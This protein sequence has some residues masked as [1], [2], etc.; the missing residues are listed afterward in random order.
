MNFMKNLAVL[1]LLL[2]ALAFVAKPDDAFA[3][4]V[5]VQT[6]LASN[7]AVGASRFTVTSATGFVAS[8][9]LLDQVAYI[10]N[11]A[12]RI[13][14]IVGTTIY[15]QPGYG[16]TPDTAHAS[17]S[18]VFTGP[19]GGA[20]ALYSSA[21]STSSPSGRCARSTMGYAPIINVRTGQFY[22]CHGGEW[23]E[24]TA[25]RAVALPA[26]PTNI[27]SIPVGSVAYA[28]LGTSTTTVAG[29]IYQS[30]IFVP[31]TFL[32]TGVRIL[33]NGT[34]ATDKFIGALFDIDGTL[35]ANSAVAGV[36]TVGANTFLTLPFTAPK[37]ITGPAYYVIAAQGNGTTDGLRT[38]AT[39]TYVDINGKSQTGAFGTLPAITPAITFTAGTA[40]IGCIY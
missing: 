37:L 25:P 24:Q 14:N 12:Y 10:N 18:T 40:P 16:P 11:E 31:R 26:V 38:V 33:Q 9:Q 20:A 39:I 5:P 28:S 4:A 29:T 3:Q 23:I 1:A 21:F 15:V 6:T 19:V 30:S 2:I 27:C 32:A 22:D 7:V 35:L 17:G 36:T 8:T 13:T 34:V